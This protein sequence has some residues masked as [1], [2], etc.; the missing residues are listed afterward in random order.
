MGRDDVV[1]AVRRC[2]YDG[3]ECPEKDE[4]RLALMSGKTPSEGK[5]E[6][7][8]LVSLVAL[9]LGDCGRGRGGGRSRTGVGECD[10]DCER[11][12]VL[13]RSVDET[14]F[15]PLH[16]SKGSSTSTNTVIPTTARAT[17]DLGLG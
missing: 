14:A 4:L 15:D 12:R 11:L 2:V 16:S 5:E 8:C 3:V 17:G 6:E 1:L 7:R 10:S 13:V 9:G